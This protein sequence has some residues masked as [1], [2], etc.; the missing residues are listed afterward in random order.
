MTPNNFKTY[1]KTPTKLEK[2]A[3][4]IA[5]QL[6]CYPSCTPNCPNPCMQHPSARTLKARY[7]SDNQDLIPRTPDNPPQPPARQQPQHPNPPPNI[8]NHPHRFPINIILHHK[9]NV[10]KDKY[11]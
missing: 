3:L 4:N 6:F 8:I 10:S 2:N 7:I 11:K 9:T 5:K 1:Y